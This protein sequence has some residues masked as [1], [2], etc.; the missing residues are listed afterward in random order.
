[1]TRFRNIHSLEIKFILVGFWNTLFSIGLF[2][3]FL[4]NLPSINYQL[5]LFFCFLVS[6]IQSHFTQRNLV[7]H[8]NKKQF[9]E[10]LKFFM[11]NVSLYITNA[12]TL[13][14]LLRVSKL[15]VFT[16]QVLLTFFL[17]F[18]NYLIQ[19]KIVFK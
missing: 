18:L 16:A 6:T 5:A 7:W 17:T 8:S 10:L 15:D 9:P 11:I 13:P 14:F 12:I 2:Y 4:Q 19:K 1:M 3:I